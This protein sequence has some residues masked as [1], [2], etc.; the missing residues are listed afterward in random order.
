MSAITHMLA[1]DLDGT[2]VGEEDGL[3]QLINYY[4]NLPYEVALVYITGR[5]LESAISLIK[6]ENLSMPKL[7]V[8]DVGTSIYEGSN[9][10]A[11]PEWQEKMMK[12]W[13]PHLI[14]ELATNFP[15]IR[16][17][18]LPDDRR[19]SF[20]IEADNNSAVVGKFKNALDAA[21]IAHKFIFSSGRDIDILP[22]GSGKGE[23]LRYIV[24]K[25]ADCDTSILVAGDSGN[26]LE[27][28]TLGYPSVIVANAREELLE[29]DE[30]PKLFRAT[31]NC[32]GGIH[33]AWNHFYG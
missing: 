13:K 16:L 17:Q 9:K 1:T 12:D 8:T 14:R 18:Q 30:H 6:S 21:G 24:E 3:K 7:L 31:K 29:I 32:A 23:A 5:H 11:D 33:E 20:E 25:Y 27:M 22:I 15:Q 26:D 28:L 4:E 2:L 19:V 10:Q